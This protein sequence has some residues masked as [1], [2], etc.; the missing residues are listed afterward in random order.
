M[1]IHS[2]IFECIPIFL[3]KVELKIEY[4]TKFDKEYATQYLTEAVFLKRKGIRYEFVKTVNG[5]TTYKYKKTKELFDALSEFYSI[6]AETNN[7]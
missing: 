6:E 4:T 1:G 5:L 7:M 2:L 3:R